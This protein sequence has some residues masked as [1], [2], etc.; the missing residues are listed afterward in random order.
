LKVSKKREFGFKKEMQLLSYLAYMLWF[1]T[2]T[3]T[4]LT[5]NTTMYSKTNELFLFS[6]GKTNW[7]LDRI[8]FLAA[9]IYALH[10]VKTV[11]F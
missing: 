3:S 1:I 8:K 11:H 7:N 5:V 10:K 2:V 9:F 4:T 6:K